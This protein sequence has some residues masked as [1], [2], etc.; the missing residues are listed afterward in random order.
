MVTVNK[1][2]DVKDFWLD[3]K[4]NTSR[5]HENNYSSWRKTTNSK[6]TAVK[7]YQYNLCED[8]LIYGY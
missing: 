1:P 6:T 5:D 4:N 8:G 3:H 2:H 7:Q